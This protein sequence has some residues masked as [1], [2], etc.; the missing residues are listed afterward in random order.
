VTALVYGFIRA[1]RRGWGDQLDAGRLRHGRG[2]A[3]VFVVTETRARQPITPMRLFAD[4]SRAGL[5]HR[6]AA[7]DRG[8]VRD[9]LLHHRVPAEDHGLQPAA[10]G[11]AFL[12]MTVA[13]FAVSRLA[14]KLC[15]GWARS[16]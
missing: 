6:P 10:A 16:R 8:H 11:V 13:L 3:A 2:R 1:G 9:V 4:V 15:R 7:A 5:V 12:P 14:P